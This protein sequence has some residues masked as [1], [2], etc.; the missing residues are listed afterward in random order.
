MSDK[1]DTAYATLCSSC[2]KAC[3]QPAF[4]IV[5]TCPRYEMS[6]EW[7]KAHPKRRGRKAAEPK[8]A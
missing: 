5:I 2:T 6:E 4:D 7:L 3:K 1:Q 8:E